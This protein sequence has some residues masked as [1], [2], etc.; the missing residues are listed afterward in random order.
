MLKIIIDENIALAQQ[1]FKQV[2]QVTLLPG[3][4]IS[5][6]EIKK[7][8]ILIVRSVTKVDKNLLKDTTVKFVGTATIGTDHIDLDYLINSNIV[9]ADAKGCNAYSVAEYVVTALLDIATKFNF[10]LKE[11]KLGIIGVGNIGSKV[12]KFAE[13]LGMT[14]LLNDPPLQR[15]GDKR[16]FVQLDEIINS[17]IITLHV[18]LNK[19]GTDKTFHLFEKELLKKLNDNTIIINTSRGA[20]IDNS[21]L[22][23]IIKKKNLK[24]VLDVWENEPTVNIDLLNN[25]VIGTSHIAGYSLEGKVNGTLMI[26]SALCNFLGV[27]KSFKPEDKHLANREIDLIESQSV[28]QTL[29]GLTSKIYNIKKDNELMKQMINKSKDEQSSYFNNL[30]KNYETRREFSNYKIK[31]NKKNTEIKKILEQFRF[32]LIN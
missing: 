14:V 9:F 24:V 22:S 20:V 23:E 12:A 1:A 26:Y 31:L 25:V 16:E 3:N 17:D 21:K 6:Q 29:N 19:A 28:E 10:I 2:G 7:A 13:A 27:K 15:K 11:K 32:K 18:P 4:K 8:D 30:R 5:N